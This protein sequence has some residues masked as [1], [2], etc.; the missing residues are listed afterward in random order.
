MEMVE[1]RADG[2]VEYRFVH[3]SMYR[4]VQQQFQI[5]VRGMDPDRMVQ[6]LQH[7]RKPQPLAIA[8]VPF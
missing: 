3:N 4:E 2:S 7:N 5:C 6:L 1:K 8:S